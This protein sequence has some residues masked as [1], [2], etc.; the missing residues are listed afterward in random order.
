MT[1]FWLFQVSCILGLTS[2]ESLSQHFGFLNYFMDT[3][4]VVRSFIQNVLPMLLVTL[5]MSLLPWILLG[6]A[7]KEIVQVYSGDEE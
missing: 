5:F 7:N 2:I 1:I 4:D 6:K 3:S